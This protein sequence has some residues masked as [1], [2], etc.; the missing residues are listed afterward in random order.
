MTTFSRTIHASP[1]TGTTIIQVDRVD[2]QADCKASNCRTDAWCEHDWLL[3]V[4]QL[5][6]ETSQYECPSFIVARANQIAALR[7]VR[8]LNVGVRQTSGS[9]EAR[10]N[11]GFGPK[12]LASTEKRLAYNAALLAHLNT[13]QK[14]AP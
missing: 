4:G 2:G 7:D 12:Q 10:D 11:D 14:D 13:D 1:R 9:I 3:T 5:N 6:G 8:H